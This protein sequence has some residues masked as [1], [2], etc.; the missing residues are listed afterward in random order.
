MLE[1]LVNEDLPLH[2]RIGDLE[3]HGQS[4][5]VSSKLHHRIGDLEINHVCMFLMVN[6]HH[7]IGDLE[8][9]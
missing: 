5:I 8:I 3:M 6:L 2:H 9:I 1:K 4:P 7:R